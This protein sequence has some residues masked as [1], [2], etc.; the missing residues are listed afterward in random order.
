MTSESR[1]TFGNRVA[2]SNMN[3]VSSRASRELL[4]LWFSVNIELIL[5]NDS[6]DFERPDL[7]LEST[8]DYYVEKDT[9]VKAI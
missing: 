9:P 6:V 4:R 5:M 3:T 2:P 1:K 8:D 7:Q